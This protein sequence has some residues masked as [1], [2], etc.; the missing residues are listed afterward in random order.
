MIVTHH[1]QNPLEF[2]CQ[3]LI[4]YNNFTFNFHTPQ[5]A[6]RYAVALCIS[7]RDI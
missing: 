5:T 4:K 1:R 2:I 3:E 7:G 6:L